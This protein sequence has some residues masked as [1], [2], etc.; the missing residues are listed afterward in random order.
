MLSNSRQEAFCRFWV[1][2]NPKHDPGDSA[3]PLDTRG[4]G[5]Q[6]YIAA[7]YKARGASADTAAWRML[8]N[9][10]VQ[11]R[12]A[13]LR[14]EEERLQGVYLQHWKSLL[15]KAQQ[16]LVRAM[17]EVLSGAEIRPHHITAAREVIEQAVGPSRL[18]FGAQN[19]A[20]AGGGINVTLWSG[21]KNE[22]D[23]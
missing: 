8:R 3:S 18:R 17:D 19:G 13:E 23:G 4:N 12:I 16:V 15:S 7:G 11:D 6:S 14:S 1:F 5:R 22:E 20:N 2:G 10:E 9:V 21:S